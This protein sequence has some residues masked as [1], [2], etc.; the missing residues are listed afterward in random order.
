MTWYNNLCKRLLEWPICE[1]PHTKVSDTSLLDAAPL[2]FRYQA[3]GEFTGHS[4][5]ILSIRLALLLRDRYCDVCTAG[6][7]ATA[8]LDF[9]RMVSR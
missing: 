8:R 6:R 5:G 3:S 4:Y 7:K 1:S 2:L 9:A